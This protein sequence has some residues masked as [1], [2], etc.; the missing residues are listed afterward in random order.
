MFESRGAEC[1]EW[2]IVGGAKL[3]ALF[4]AEWATNR[5]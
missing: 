4:L 1:F 5:R 3:V 2:K